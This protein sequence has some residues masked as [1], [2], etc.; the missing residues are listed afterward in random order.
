MVLYYF[1]IE[2]ILSY[3]FLKGGIIN[4]ILRL[5]IVVGIVIGY[6]N[7]TSASASTTVDGII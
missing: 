1:L 7:G 2:M 6:N 4:H 5:V 3:H